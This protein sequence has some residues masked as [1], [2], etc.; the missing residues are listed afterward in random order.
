MKC[1]SGRRC[2]N[3]TQGQERKK[4][5]NRKFVKSHYETVRFYLDKET[6]EK[7][8]F[9]DLCKDRGKTPSEVLREFVRT[10]LKKY[11]Y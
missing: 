7:A 11:D 8:R 4:A 6:A 2:N 3:A 5:Y 10:M 1:L 9:S